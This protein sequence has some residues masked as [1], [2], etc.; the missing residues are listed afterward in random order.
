[1]SPAVLSSVGVDIEENPE[2]NAQY[3]QSPEEGEGGVDDVD[4]DLGL[5]PVLGAVPYLLFSSRL[6]PITNSMGP[7]STI[8]P[9]ILKQG[10]KNES[11]DGL[12]RIAGQSGILAFGVAVLQYSSKEQPVEPSVLPDLIKWP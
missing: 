11:N 8:S 4:L 2:F 1:L 7:I 12:K 5:A 10:K 9:C 3:D 6:Y